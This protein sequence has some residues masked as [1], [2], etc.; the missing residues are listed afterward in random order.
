LI[1][2]SHRRMKKGGADTPPAYLLGHSERELHRLTRQ[3]RLVDPI[4]RRFFREA[5][6]E[7]GMRVLDIG[8]GVGDVAFLLADMV[9]PTGEVVGVDRSSTALAM[10]RERAESRSLRNVTLHEG[11][12]AAMTFDRP[13]DAVAGRYVLMF[14]KDPAAILRAVAAHAKPRAPIVFHEPDWSGVRSHPPVPIYDRCCEWIIEVVRRSGAEE[15]MGIK[16]HAAFVAA[17]LPPPFVGLE[18]VIG[19][20]EHNR[21]GMLLIS[22]LVDT[23]LPE[24][25]RWGVATAEEVD[26]PTLAE[27]MQKE[28]AS[29]GSVLV[30]RCEVG[31]WT[32]VQ[33]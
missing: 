8:S 29:R 2:E 6:I 28:A 19:G 4:T 31:A 18:A 17:G 23:L 27:R 7:P 16:L 20:T 33:G 15:H 26:W 25:E 3:A 11:D 13:F 9:G 1:H 5:G 12:A 24:M 21:D 32:R 14:Q 22:D 30:G 10:A